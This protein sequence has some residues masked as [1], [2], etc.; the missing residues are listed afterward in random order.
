MPRDGFDATKHTSPILQVV[1]PVVDGII[2]G[3]FKNA[4]EAVT[5]AEKL[6]ADPKVVQM[7]KLI[8]QDRGLN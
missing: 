1:E 3:S 2:Q 6:G 5:A 4:A 7:V 8:A